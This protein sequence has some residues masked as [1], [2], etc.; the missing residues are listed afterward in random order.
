[1][2][3]PGTDAQA[4]GAARR[5]WLTPFYR[6][7]YSVAGYL[8]FA[9]MVMVGWDSSVINHEQIYLIGPHRVVDPSFLAHDFTWSHLP[10]TSFLHD[11]LMAP[12]WSFMTEFQVANVGRFV[13]WALLAW[14][15][16]LVA[17]EIAVPPWSMVVGFYLW[18]MWGQ[19]FA[20]CGWLIEG[21]QVKS[22]AYPMIF[23]SLAFALRGQAVRAGMAAGLGAAF[24]IIV[25]GWGC[26]AVFLTMLLERSI[27]PLRKLLAFLAASAPFVLPL[28]LV[29]G[30][31][32]TANLS[33]GERARLDEIYVNFASPHCC[34]VDWFMSFSKWVRAALIFAIAPLLIFRWPGR[35]EVRTLGWFV[36]TLIGFFGV[37]MLAD[38]VSAYAI[39]KLFPGQLGKA[40]PALFV[41]VFF[42]A[43]LGTRGVSR[44]FP[45][46]VWAGIFLAVVLLIDDRDAMM[47][48]TDA[49][50]E[51]VEELGHADWGLP[52][53]HRQLFEWIRTST[54]EDSVFITPMVDEFWPYA[55]RAQVASMRHPPFDAKLIEWKERL[56]AQNG[57]KPFENRG[58]MIRQE[59]AENEGKLTPEQIVRLR[60]LYGATH[61]MSETKR[62]ELERHLVQEDEEYF[63][64]DIREL[65][66]A[67]I[68]EVPATERRTRERSRSRRSS[69]D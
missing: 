58:W 42:F 38:A 26:L 25:G 2:T 13:T 21:F 17:R 66:P 23:F 15:L 48:A 39:L 46:G 34:D 33:S 18:V 6:D 37:A 12:F 16:A 50:M 27:Y 14:S 64:Y 53:E 24:H 56:E 40:I 47:S 30:L 4:A 68:E 10:P 44:R 54:P 63:V 52:D 11:R 43:H 29:V 7:R 36:V 62:P 65:D 51:F 8:L 61:Y 49:P 32:H 1:M 5:R 69:P 45:R 35:R 20:Y 55:Q 9:V 60:E 31:F 59:L 57:F 3:L 22:F 67:E 19:S 41:F 28:V